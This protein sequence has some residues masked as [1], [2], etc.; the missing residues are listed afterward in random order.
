MRQDVLLGRRRVV[1]QE[2]TPTN[3][4]PHPHP[5]PRREQLPPCFRTE[6][7][8]K[9]GYTWPLRMWL[10]EK[11]GQDA[12]LGLDDLRGEIPTFFSGRERTHPG[13]PLADSPRP[14]KQA[15]H[16]AARSSA[17]SPSTSPSTP[18]TKCQRCVFLFCGAWE[19]DSPGERQ[20]TETWTFLS[21]ETKTGT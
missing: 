6:K 21:H 16:S 7:E 2:A 20:K 17:R 3:R 4:R 19:A 14:F 11:L 8:R 9:K 18:S 10:T 1:A 12:I 13:T 15:G 5:R